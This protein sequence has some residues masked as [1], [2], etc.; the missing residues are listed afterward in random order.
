MNINTLRIDILE[1][2]T[3][4]KQAPHKHDTTFP[5]LNLPKQNMDLHYAL[6][7]YIILQFLG[8]LNNLELYIGSFC[9]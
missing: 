9:N 7:I 6:W 4:L 5:I 8:V 2:Y 3:L 1:K